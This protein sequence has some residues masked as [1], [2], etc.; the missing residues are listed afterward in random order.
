MTL[1]ALLIGSETF[2]LTGCNADVALMRDVLTSHNFAE[3]QVLVDADATRD[4]IL[5]GFEWLIAASAAH[6]AALVFYSG[7]GGRFPLPDWQARQVA[8]QDAFA[9]FI[10]PYDMAQTTAADFRGLLSLEMSGLQSRLTAKTDN[11]TTILDCCHSGL[12]SRDATL[13]PK[14][15]SREFPIDGALAKLAEIEARAGAPTADGNPDAVRVVACAP[16]QS[17]FEGLSQFRPGERHGLLTDALANLLNLPAGPRVGWRILAERLRA[18]VSAAAPM[19]RPEVEGPSRRLPFTVEEDERPGALPVQVNAGEIWVDGAELL[20]VSPGDRYLLLD[21]SGHELGTATAGTLTGG[22]AQLSADNCALDLHMAVTAVPLR[23]SSRLPVSVELPDPL[24]AT[25]LTAIEA[26]GALSVSETGKPAIASVTFDDGLL[27]I[28]S[29]RVPLHAGRLG[30]DAKGIRAATTLIENVAHAYR[31]RSLQPAEVSSRLSAA[32][33]RDVLASLRRRD[34]DGDRGQRRAPVRGGSSV[35]DGPQP[36]GGPAVLL[37]VRCRHRFHD[38]AGDQR[39]TV[40]T[41]HLAGRRAGRHSECRRP[42]RYP[43]V[44]AGLA[45]GRRR[46]AGGLRRNRGRSCSG[47]ELAADPREGP[48]RT[49]GSDAVAGGAGGSQHSGQELA[50][51]IGICLGFAS[52]PRRYV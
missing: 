9:Q 33:G 5:A 10:V 46:A 44:L 32:G 8:G 42:F 34:A 20:A 4:G 38:R 2:G 35:D 37:A 51:G 15:V 21:G 40:R 52:V 28:D 14:A 49:A 13:I 7:H 18:M 12:M 30:T 11:V 23:T 31:F 3:I 29:A 17:A 48:R 45:P 39:V 24:R 43:A 22:R 6:D 1:R 36:R 27:I 41:A 19:Q 25:M 50:G 26:S 16:N 47:S